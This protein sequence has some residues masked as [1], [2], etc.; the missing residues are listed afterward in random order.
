MPTSP[1]AGNRGLA[2]AVLLTVLLF[3]VPYGRIL[4][5]PF[6]LLATWFHEMGHGLTAALLGGEFNNLVLRPDTSGFATYH[7]SGDFGTLR[8]AMV[9][10][11]GYL[12]TAAVGCVLLALRQR[13]SVQRASLWVL[14]AALLL[15][16]VKVLR[17]PSNTF[18]QD[19]SFWM[20]LFGAVVVVAWA[21]AAAWVSRRGSPTSLAFLYNLIAA[22]TALNAVTDARDLYFVSQHS[23][24]DT[25]AS[26]LLLPSWIWAT[27]WLAT[28]LALTGVGLYLGRG[29]AGTPR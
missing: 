12:G 21:G 26:L 2:V 22:Q 15:S 16:L 20:P 3:N 11:A 19:F 23:D 24:A 27:L 18:S 25:L 9:S 7:H 4:L 14:S 1:L 10:S 6:A 28:A 29:A 8:R 17:W 5:Y 13:V